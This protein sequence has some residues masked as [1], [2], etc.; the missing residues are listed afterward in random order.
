[1]GRG[2][3]RRLGLGGAGGIGVGLLGGS[4]LAACQHER[5]GSESR[6][7]RAEGQLHDSIPSSNDWG[8]AC[9]ATCSRRYKKVYRASAS[10]DSP[11]RIQMYAA[12]RPILRVHAGVLVG[13]T[14]VRRV[15]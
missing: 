4:G 1:G 8:Q 11:K 15:E 3:L 7:Q 2:L 14:R 13:A 6:S 5:Q 12:I 10:P 9:Q